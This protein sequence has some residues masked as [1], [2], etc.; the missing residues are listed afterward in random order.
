MQ[1]HAEASRDLDGTRVQHAR[2]MRGQFQHRVVVDTRDLHGLRHDARIGRVDAIH[3]GVDLAPLRIQGRCQR[4]RGRVGAAAAQGRHLTLGAHPLE[5]GHDDDPSRGQRGADAVAAHVEDLRIGVTAIG[6]DA[7]LRA[8]ERNGRA[9]PRLQGDGQQRHRDALAGSEQHVQFAGRGF[10]SDAAR[11][12]EEVIGGVAHGRD[13]YDHRVTGDLGRHD[14]VRH[15]L[16]AL[17]AGDRSASV[18][19]YQRLHGP[20]LRGNRR[21]PQALWRGQGAGPHRSRCSQRGPGGLRAH[22]EDLGGDSVPRQ[23]CGRAPPGHR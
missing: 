11:E 12:R 5:P 8:G 13:D 4:H 14:T 18:F 17:G 6:D 23:D 19:L 16:D 15:R 21:A 10:G 3:I 7:A 22:A 20:I 2:A 1:R 9:P